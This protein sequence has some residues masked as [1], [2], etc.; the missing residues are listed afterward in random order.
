MRKFIFTIICIAGLALAQPAIL[1]CATEYIT[2]DTDFIVEEEQEFIDDHFEISIDELPDEEIIQEEVEEFEEVEEILEDKEDIQIDFPDYGEDFS[3]L[4]NELQLLNDEVSLLSDYSGITTAIPTTYLDYMRDVLS[5]SVYGEKYVAFSSSYYLYNNTY[6]YYVLVVSDT[7]TWNGSRFTG[8]DVDV[9]EFFPQITNYTGNS[10]Y[11]HTIQSFFSYS[12]NG[13]LCF[14][15][16][17][18]EY[19]NIRGTTNNYLFLFTCIFALALIF[20][21]VS[22]FGFGNR[23]FRRRPKRRN[24]TI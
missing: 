23:H 3:F 12:P 16:L 15:D 21:T 20:Y 24:V 19:P 7:L 13:F 22:S 4:L 6:T 9:Y 10:N 14:T 1:S 2:D 5:W 11:R 18:S 17:S 8:S